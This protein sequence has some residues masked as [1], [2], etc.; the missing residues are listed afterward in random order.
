MAAA[1]FAR[2]ESWRLS[3]SGFLACAD[4]RRRWIVLISFASKYEDANAD[5][6]DGDKSGLVTD[7]SSLSCLSFFSNIF[8]RRKFSD[9]MNRVSH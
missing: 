9:T 6:A 3:L 8:F 7:S 4:D 5:D 1:M 2:S